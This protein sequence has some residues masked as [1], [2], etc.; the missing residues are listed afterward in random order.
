MGDTTAGG[1]TDVISRELPNGW[2]YFVGVGDYRNAKGES[3]EGI[4][5]APGIY[6]VNTKEDID[7][8]K[9]KV[10]ERAISKVE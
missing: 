1:F 6:V 9:D 7:A 10:L 8:G 3:E 5:V 4:G 2:L